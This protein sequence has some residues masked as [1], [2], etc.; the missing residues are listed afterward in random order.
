MQSAYDELVDAHLAVPSENGTNFIRTTQTFT[1]W[2]ELLMSFE[3]QDN[4]AKL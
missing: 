3:F 4:A 2:H 1:E